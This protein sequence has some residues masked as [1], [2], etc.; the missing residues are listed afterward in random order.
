MG[1]E[2]PKV[3]AYVPKE[4]LSALDSWKGENNIESRSAAIV[5]ILA[6]YLG[7]TY[8]VRQESNAPTVPS[9][10]LS[11]V[12]A[13]LAKLSSRVA[14]LEQQMVGSTAVQEV[15]S[16]ALIA[17]QSST[18]PK[19]DVATV[20]EA[21]DNVLST[22]PS[23]EATTASEVQSKALSTAP[24]QPPAVL[25]QMA[26]ARRLGVSDKAVEKHRKQGKESFAEWSRTRDRQKIAWSWEGDGGRGQ[27]LRFMPLD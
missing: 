23:S 19:E 6:D 27:P 21:Q 26:L 4:I 10:A 16:T 9:G 13:E 25:T 12:L 20:S 17:K 2:H 14:A 15:P 18:A 11:T 8:P 5:T 24:L 1:T 7:V 22:V 3:T